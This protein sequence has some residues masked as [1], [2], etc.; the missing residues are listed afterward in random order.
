MPR[1]RWNT[2]KIGI[3][4]QSINQSIQTSNILFS[5]NYEQ[6][7]ENQNKEVIK[8]TFFLQQYVLTMNQWHT[9]LT[10]MSIV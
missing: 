8:Q 10:Y 4:H 3:K 5:E 6:N 2:A 7:I 9:L 1:Y